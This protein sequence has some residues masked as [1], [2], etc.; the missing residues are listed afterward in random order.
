MPPPCLFNERRDGG[1]GP[2]VEFAAVDRRWCRYASRCACRRRGRCDRRPAGRAVV[3]HDTGRLSRPVCVAGFVRP[4]RASR[5]RRHRRVRCRPGPSP[6]RVRCGP[7][8]RSTPTQSAGASPQREVRRAGPRS[9]RHGP[10]CHAV[11]EAPRRAAPATWKH[12]VRCWSRSVRRVRSGSRRQASSG[13]WSSP[14]PMICACGSVGSRPR[15]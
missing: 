8:S 9:R 13:I 6:R 10:R 3:S 12:C 7:S 4:N 5:G 1:Y 15:H 14:R 11:L 2:C